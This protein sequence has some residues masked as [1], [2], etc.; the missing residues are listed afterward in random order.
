MNPAEERA[1]AG[2]RAELHRVARYDDESIVHD[3]WIRQ[4]Y[5]CGCNCGW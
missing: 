1:L 4:R 3:K 5:D 2:I